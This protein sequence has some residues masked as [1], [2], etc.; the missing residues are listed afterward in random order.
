M[1]KKDEKVY[2]NDQWNE[3]VIHLK[4]FIK[5]GDQEK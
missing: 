2:F 5:T 4:A 3:M 1:K